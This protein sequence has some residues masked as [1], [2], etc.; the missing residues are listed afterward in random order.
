MDTSSI[1]IRYSALAQES[2][3][4]SCGGAINYAKPQPGEICID[5][6]SGRGTDVLRMAD[7]VGSKG[8]VYGVDISDGM[9]ETATANAEKLGITNVSFLKSD[10]EH[11]A[12]PGGIANLVISNCTINHA[13]DKLSVWKEIYRMLKP[14]GRFVVS[15]I[16][17]TE[18]VPEE[19]RNDPVAVS[20]CWA[21]AVTR[22]EYMKT[23]DEAGFSNISVMEESKPYK[24]GAVFVSSF[25]IFGKKASA[26]CCCG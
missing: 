7:E 24:K 9:L 10:L 25:T 17:S 13:S 6:G 23:L 16:Y 26:C 19:Y 14:G 2:C 11:I 3:C 12:I 4:L 21:G 20:E 5:L 8:F 18:P 22:D 15:D 1:N